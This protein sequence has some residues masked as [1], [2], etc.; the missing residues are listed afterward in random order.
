MEHG[1]WGNMNHVSNPGRLRRLN[2]IPNQ[3]YLLRGRL[4]NIEQSNFIQ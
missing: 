3:I 4:S 1:A 2:L